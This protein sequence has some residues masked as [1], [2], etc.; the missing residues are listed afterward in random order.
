VPGNS[1]TRRVWLFRSCVDKRADFRYGGGQLELLGGIMSD[2]TS[3][4]AA[5]P[6]GGAGCLSRTTAHLG[7]LLAGLLL[8]TVVLAGAEAPVQPNEKRHSEPS[9]NTQRPTD[10]DSTSQTELEPE[11]VRD[12]AA[13]DEVEVKEEVVRSKRIREIIRRR[14]A[15][16]T[17][18]LTCEFW[19][20]DGDGRREL[21]NGSRAEFRFNPI[22]RCSDGRCYA[23]KTPIVEPSALQ[24]KDLGPYLWAC[25]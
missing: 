8:V 23:S 3:V 5:P 13:P 10:S 12:T 1:L 14:S 19:D 18:P 16:A 24:K 20:K 15:A 4:L 6:A 22:L 9:P 2:R 11:T 7:T 25:P 21:Y 17:P